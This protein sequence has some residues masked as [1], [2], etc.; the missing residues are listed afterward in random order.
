MVVFLS[1]LIACNTIQ[2]AFKCVY[3]LH[4]SSVVSYYCDI[5]PTGTISTA[6]KL[7]HFLAVVS[8]SLHRPVISSL[9]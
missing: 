9:R 1:Q 3:C 8:S 4:I 2:C 5:G 6:N 7:C